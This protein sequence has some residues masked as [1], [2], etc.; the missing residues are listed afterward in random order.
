MRDYGEELEKRVAFIR[1]A[2]CES[3]AKG[4]IYGNSGGKDS[5]LVGILARKATEETLGVILPCQSKRNFLEDMADGLEV[6]EQ[7]D[8]KTM[9]VDLTKTKETLVKAIGEAEIGLAGPADTNINPRLRMTTLYA[10]GAQ[11]GYLVAGTG[12][13]SESYMGYFTKWGDGGYDL[14]PIHDLTVTEIYEFLAYLGA[15][16]NII[17]K[18]PS[19]GLAEGQT[20]EE[21]MGISYRTI[22]GYLLYGTATEAEQEIM[23]RAHERTA[24]KRRMPLVY[25]DDAK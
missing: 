8:I 23:K 3:G 11:M 17:R 18:A 7:F 5:A 13:R 16:E 21:E 9:T 19:A 14:N 20:D 10:I 12:N 2:L 4:I 25:G 24:H 22:D 1:E 15:P 6:A